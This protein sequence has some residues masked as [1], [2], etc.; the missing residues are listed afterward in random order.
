MVGPRPY[1]IYQSKIIYRLFFGV[2]KSAWIE[3]FISK[4]VLPCPA[5]DT[6]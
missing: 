3:H 5:K 4:E 2:L 1:K 6:F